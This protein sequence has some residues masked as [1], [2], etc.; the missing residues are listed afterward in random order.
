MATDTPKQNV[1]VLLL[2]FSK[3]FDHVD[4][5]IL[6]DK[7]SQS[8][9]PDFMLKWKH[10]FL[11]DRQHRVKIK[12]NVSSWKSPSGGTP[13]GTK[14][15]AKDFKKMVKD[16]KAALPVFKYVDDSTLFEICKRG[17]HSDLLQESAD[18]IAEW[19]RRNRM[20]INAKKTKELIIDFSKSVSPHAKI[21][22]EGQEIE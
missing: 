13:Q 17:I 14:S 1:R 3:A 6:L 12:D 21:I 20:L 16:I 8:G 7:W 22:I 19:C 9:A 15:G 11:L 5:H 4:H 18:D 10:S 2:D